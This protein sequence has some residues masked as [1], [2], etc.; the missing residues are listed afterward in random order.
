[1]TKLLNREISW[2]SFN[3]RV[4]QEAEDT[5]VPL[6]ERMRFLG[7][8]SSNQD[9]FFRVRVATVRRLQKFEKKKSAVFPD[10]PQKVLN[11]IHEVVVAQQNRFNL[12]YDDIIGELERKK[13][14]IINETQLNEEQLVFVKQYY[15][16]KVE[17]I[18]VPIILKNLKKF[19]YLSDD[20]IYLFVS[21][22]LNQPQGRKIF[23]L[24][25]VPR[26][27]LSRF[28]VLPRQD[29][30]KCIIYLEDVIRMNFSSIFS[31]FNYQVAESYIIKITRDAELDFEDDIAKGFYDK[32]MKSLE[33]RKK[34]EPVRFVYD[35]NMPMEYVNFLLKKMDLIEEENIIPGGRYHNFKDF[36]KFPNVG[37]PEL[38]HPKLPPLP[39]PDL[40]NERSLLEVIARKDVMIH[41]PYQS[42]DYIID[43][44]RE[45]A[46]DP[47]VES[48]KITLYRLA[49][50]SKI[51]NALI[52][53]AKNGKEVTVV[54]ELQ[55]R[56][57]EEA[58]L[59]WA[60][61]LKDE[62]VRLV[63]G[64]S[65]L[66]VHSKLILIDKKIGKDEY[67]QIAH[68]GTGNFHEGTATLYSDIAILTS[69][70]RI[71]KDVE[72]V[73]RL[74][75]KPYL[76]YKFDYILV[77][78]VFMRHQF[79]ELIDR[80]IKHAQLGKPSGITIKLNNVM[81]GKMIEKLYEASNAEVKIKMIVR[82]IHSLIPG[83]KGFSEHIEAISIVDKYLEH[84][85]IFVFENNGS[86]EYF[87]GS[88]DWMTR[89]LDYRIEVVVPVLDPSLCN[90]I[91]DFLD[92]QLRDNVKARIFDE[93]MKNTY[94]TRNGDKKTR[95]QVA[96]YKYLI[97]K[98]S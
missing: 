97:S 98:I 22:T 87:I 13:I 10:S 39:H 25:E 60:K 31:I 37:G 96:F 5:S 29:D 24:L 94:K 86:P 53:A 27:S 41:Y 76:P 14:L 80:E 45:A 61:I 6:V 35:Q 55:A 36:M 79:E 9:E 81:D 95:S 91:Q 47:G 33:K 44:L 90:E 67:R 85:R 19:P 4:L 1:M 26:G 78:P 52:N 3:E 18:L 43:V 32:M 48:I 8:F 75:E 30:K 57:D 92:I 7:I 51:I 2:L 73:F 68:V 65:G 93:E 17:P 11:Q 74:I 69:D 64:I 62:N 12:I 54:L 46:I 38:L 15:L 72:K 70:P 21:L 63:L 16:D 59:Q 71:T 77:S 34:G 42:F 40:M 49:S 58:N 56:F 88:A 50:D 23:S 66:K 83:K 20:S 89:N 84:S 28:L 82:G